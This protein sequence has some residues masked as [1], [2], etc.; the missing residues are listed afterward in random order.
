MN[1]YLPV[2]ILK[3]LIILPN[4]E[5][6]V[7]T[8]KDDILVT[9]S[10]KHHNGNLLLVCPRDT[11]EEEPSINDLPNIGVVGSIKNT[12][13][14]PNGNV[15][16]TV[17]GTTRVKIDEY[18]RLEDNKNIIMAITSGLTNIKNDIVSET[19]LK[20][21]LIKT[22]T[23]YINISHTISNSVLSQIAQINDLSK[24]TDIVATFIPLNFE[25]KVNY[26][27]EFDPIKRATNL[28][29]DISVE[30]EV[31]EL[32]YK[33]EDTLREEMES[34]QREYILREKLKYIKKE[35]GE[36]KDSKKVQ[37]DYFTMLDDL[38]MSTPTKN[39]IALEIKK[40]DYL[41]E[42]HPERAIVQNYLDAILSLPWNKTGVEELDLEKVKKAL[43]KS[44]YGLQDVKNRILEYV[45]LKRRN[46]NIKNPIL[47]LVGAP[48]VGKTSISIAI[49]K[50]LN[51]EFYKLSVGGLNDVTELMGS[52]RTYL[53]SNMGKIMQAIKKC[54][55][56]NPVILI[57]EIDKMVKNYNGDP[58]SALLEIIDPEQ[59]YLF[60]D[61][62]LEEPFDISNVMFIASANDIENIPPALFDRLEIIELSSYTLEEKI[63][64]VKKYLLPSIFKNY[65]ISGRD[66]KIGDDVI[67]EI[68]VSYTNEAGLRNLKRC[69]EQI[70]RKLILEYDD[71]TLKLNIT[72]EMVTKYLGAKKFE[73]TKPL[74]INKAGII[75]ALAYTPLGGVVMEIEACLFDGKGEIITTGSLGNVITESIEV[76]ISYIRSNKDY[77]KVND[78][79][80]DN[81]NIHI[82]FLEG[83]TPKDGPSAGVSITT[84]LLSLLL[85]KP[86]SKEIAMTGEIGLNGE[87]LEVG[88]IKEKLIGAY[89]NGIKTIFIPKSNTK[90]LEEI[91]K[92]ILNKLTIYGV[93]NYEEIFTK[94]FF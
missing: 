44:H 48:G 2:M 11:L 34:N 21:K 22:L 79:Y 92:D 66:V 54:Q 93:S 68:I 12:I 80:F 69:L 42:G 4:Q 86:I 55:V 18:R 52:R 74:D 40:L 45:A 53:G 38:V 90:N 28:I 63:D 94:I 59:N 5:I 73:E 13:D 72:I 14:L 24:L 57:D 23:N 25:K 15:R 7:E 81:R 51:R 1:N 37:D 29:Y 82:H 49:A 87:V 31:C 75:N 9:V 89:N 20:R 46:P 64:I 71:E 50:A 88:G 27:N 30:I 58:A 91:P 65:L 78:Y 83:A 60:T 33:I 19:A 85:N 43:T 62:Y 56:K 3:D 6:K 61:N 26:M 70:M 39:K 36:D 32:D 77:F 67:K 17:I 16:L 76:A 41:P 84:S 8:R 10:N 35:L 47:C